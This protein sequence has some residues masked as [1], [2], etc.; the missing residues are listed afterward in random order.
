MQALSPV[1]QLPRCAGDFRRRHSRW[2]LR[3]VCMA[4][5]G[6]VTQAIACTDQVLHLETMHCTR[7]VAELGLGAGRHAPRPVPRSAKASAA[8]LHTHLQ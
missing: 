2:P 4:P 8:L 3:P 6:L 1:A 5:N 7:A